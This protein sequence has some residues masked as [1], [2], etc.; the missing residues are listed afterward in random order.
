[1]TR[2]GAWLAALRVRTWPAAVVPVVVGT[3]AVAHAGRAHAGVAATALA[4]ALLIQVGTEPGERLARPPA[5]GGRLRSRRPRPRLLAG[6]LDAREVAVADALAFAGAALLELV[7]V[8]RAGWPVLAIGLASIAAGTAYTAGPYPLAYHGLGEAFV[9]LRPVGRRVARRGGAPD[10]RGERP[11][12]PGLTLRGDANGA[13]DVGAARRAAAELAPF[14]LEW[15]EQPVRPDDPVALA[16]VRRAGHVAVAADEAVTGPDAVVRG[17]RRRGGRRRVEARAGGR[18]RPG[19]FAAEAAARRGLDVTVTTALDT[20]IGRAAALHLADAGTDSPA[21]RL[22]GDDARRRR[23]R[24]SPTDRDG[25][26]TATR[27]GRLA[28]RCVVSSCMVRRANREDRA[29]FAAVAAAEAGEEDERHAPVIT[30][31]D[32][33]FSPFA[34][35]VRMVLGYKG[36]PFAS[37]D[38]LALAEHDRLLA[39]NPRGEVPVLVDGE[40]TVVNSAD[41]VTYLDHRYPD[42]PVLPADPAQRVAARAWER[43]ADGLVDAVVHDIS[44]WT[45]PTHHRDDGPPPGLIDAGHRDLRAVLGQLEAALGDGF[46]CGEISIADLALY[47]HVS[48]FRLLGVPPDADAHR[49]VVAWLGRVRA[50]P[51][52]REDVERVRRAAESTFASGRTSP[53]EGDKIVWR[54]DRLEWLFANGFHAW[55]LGELAAGRAVVPTGF[56]AP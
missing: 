33:P 22:R 11:H 36:L 31:Y 46:L 23:D 30:L 34:R 47:P 12:R 41:I 51:C 3:A 48:S 27:A 18:S 38:A 39:V 8:A 29:H 10:D 5:R 49:K 52:V 2:R 53:Y 7:L 20:G 19:T 17:R 24:R 14:A 50:L 45:W 42:R 26:G 35:K 1:V 32:N 54:G 56:R 13:W 44:I 28:A 15:R 9:F 16:R 6:V 21:R 40:V 25:G 4:A 55:W 43:L 37:I